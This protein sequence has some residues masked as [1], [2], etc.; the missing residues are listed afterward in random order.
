MIAGLSRRKFKALTVDRDPDRQGK[1]RVASKGTFY[2][3]VRIS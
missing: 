3:A 1:T 2:Y